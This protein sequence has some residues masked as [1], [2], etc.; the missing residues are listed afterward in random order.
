M[1]KNSNKTSISKTGTL[2]EIG[3]FWDNHSLADFWDQTKEVEF[4]IR[5][6]RRHRAAIDPELY[7]KIL[8]CSHK[9][10]ILPETLINLWLTEKLKESEI[11]DAK[12]I[13]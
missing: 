2:E 7:K 5:A 8:S 12:K 13:A 3:E 6:T 1:K 11:L 9:R 10:G 4:E